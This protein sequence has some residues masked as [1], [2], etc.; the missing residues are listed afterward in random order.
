MENEGDLELTEPW[1]P[2]SELETPL[3]PESKQAPWWAWVIIALSVAGVG[4]LVYRA[5]PA[6]HP[7]QHNPNF[8]DNVFANN[9][10]LFAARLVLFS[11][12]VVLAVMAVYVIYSISRWMASGQSLT[13]FGPFEVQAVEDLSADVE[14]WR[15]LWSEE[16]D[17]N[18]QLRS[19]LEETD[20]LFSQLYDEFQGVVA[21]LAQYENQGTEPDPPGHA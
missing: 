4:F 5:Y 3:E 10:V 2:D 7:Q 20:N 21:R 9:L 11:A 1:E 19:Q 15:N 18:V 13:K 12:A 8:I 6:H 17:E 14:M 16:T